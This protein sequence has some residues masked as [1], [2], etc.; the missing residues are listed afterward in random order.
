MASKKN[1]GLSYPSTASGADKKK[2]DAFYELTSI[3]FPAGV[4]NIP[5]RE[6]VLAKVKSGSFSVRD[7][8]IMKMANEGVF[9]GGN[10]LSTAETKE[11]GNALKDVFPFTQT[12]QQVDTFR[13]YVKNLIKAGVNLDQDYNKFTQ[14][15]LGT[16]KKSTVKN[17]SP[18]NNLIASVQKPDYTL[19]TVG[20]KGDRR[21][22]KG[23]IPKNLLTEVLG[24][25][26]S[27]PDQNMRN[28]VVASLLGYRGA[29]VAGTRTS[30]FL[31][32]EGQ[33][34]RP[35]YDLES[36]ESGV[37][38]D[39]EFG[40]QDRKQIGGSKPLGPVMK[41]I[42]DTGLDA[43][44][45]TGE[46]F[47]D[48]ETDDISK[49][50]KKYVFP[51]I[52]PAV[53]ALL[54]KPPTGYTDLRRITASAIV[55]DLANEAYEAGDTAR[56]DMFRKLGDQLIG[57][58]IPD[59]NVY[60]KVLST[61]YT[62]VED[63]ADMDQRKDVL[64][65]FERLLAT[66]L[67]LKDGAELSPRNLAKSL[68]LKVPKNFNPPKYTEVAPLQ[69]TPEGK[70]VGPQSDAPVSEE[71]LKAEAEGAVASTQRQTAT[72]AEIATQKR[73]SEAEQ[74]I[75]GEDK[76]KEAERIKA[77][78]KKVGSDIKKETKLKE[79]ED[80][81]KLKNKNAADILGEMANEYGP[82]DQSKPTGKLRNKLMTAAGVVITGA[83][84]VLG[85]VTDVAAGVA[86]PVGKALGS[87][88]PAGGVAAPA[89]ET[90]GIAATAYDIS[91]LQKTPS[92]QFVPE[93]V[94]SFLTEPEFAKE[95]ERAKS[96]RIALESVGLV[97]GAADPS[98][99]QAGR[100]AFPTREEQAA[101]DLLLKQKEEQR[102]G[103]QSS[104]GESFR[105]G[106]NSFL[107]TN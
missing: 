98:L 83:K 104:L 28:A 25:I 101:K 20:I 102:L 69:K 17:V 13:D 54:D 29:D 90:A 68:G 35:V 44:S 16:L 86:V 34:N 19:P 103:I 55:N 89:L 77:E 82:V 5:T 9:V 10:I 97:P 26:N 96:K 51:K 31:V 18:L 50:L 32:G 52:D 94:R 47:P 38:K 84:D 1:L 36:K 22:A 67:K 53:I 57:H 27:I 39:I 7:A 21:L 60:G 85:A 42:Y 4:E 37:V 62:G 23:A 66:R 72:D 14:T 6:E 11:M 79:K 12:P 70:I 43:A 40:L 107:N 92:E 46:I 33:K 41:L 8:W 76:L 88:G 99:G 59:S 87:L 48:I 95:G 91:R 64:Y 73:L 45:E 100:M 106:S 63:V 3:L 75:E 80:A 58:E 65:Q 105:V 74:L 81:Q 30:A 71:L 56:A 2:V 93:Q 24:A 78:L 61:F 49:A 15:T